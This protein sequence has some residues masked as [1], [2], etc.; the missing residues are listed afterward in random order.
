MLHLTFGIEYEVV[1]NVE[2]ARQSYPKHDLSF[3][4]SQLR[5]TLWQ[6]LAF[7]LSVRILVTENDPRLI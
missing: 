1:T 6:L 4:Y 7:S 2:L 3:L 5:I